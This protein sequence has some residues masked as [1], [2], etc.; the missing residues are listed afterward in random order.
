MDREKI[1]NVMPAE[2]DIKHPH[3]PNIEIIKLPEEIIA[4]Y[5]ILNEKCD[6]ILR[7]IKQKKT[8]P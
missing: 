4:K 6:E 1:R 5:K 8:C 3:G 2:K 7:K